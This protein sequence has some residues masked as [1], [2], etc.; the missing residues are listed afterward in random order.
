MQSEKPAT[1][2]RKTRIF[3]FTLA[4]VTGQV[5]CFTFVI[6]VAAILGGLWLDNYFQTKPMFTLGLLIV[7]IPISIAVM[8]I[9]VRFATSKFRIK[10]TDS[11]KDPKEADIGRN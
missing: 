7:S 6:I 8:I 4:S 11:T 2:E 3:N 10:P 1:S 9:V 5:G